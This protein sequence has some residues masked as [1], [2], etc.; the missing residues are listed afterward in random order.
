M[1]GRRTIS[2]LTPCYN[3]EEGIAECHRRIRDLFATSLSGYDY[4]HVFIDN[5]SLDR[6]VEILKAIAATDRRVKIIV[7]SRNFGAARS[8]FHGVLETRGNAVIPVLAD[9]QTP[10]DVIPELIAKWEEGYSIVAAVRTGSDEGWFIGQCRKVFYSVM[11]RFSGIEQIPNFIGFGLYDQSV[12]ALMRE[13]HEPEPYFR[14]M[15]CE[16]G[17]EKAFVPYQQPPRRHGKSSYNFIGL[18]D[19]AVLGLTSYS[20]VPLRIMTIAGVALSALSML[21]AI[22]YLVIKLVRWETFELG[23]APLLIGTFFFA[24]VQLLFVGLIG[25]YVGAIYAQVKRR[26]LVIERERVNFDAP[27]P[28]ANAD[29]A[30]SDVTREPHSAVSP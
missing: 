19:Y 24:S 2:I 15:V 5:C 13:L 30:Y 25:E 4:E 10:P 9:L 18:L 17:F 6:T 20:K 22:S 3:E 23:L 11:T 14:G 26:P 1:M 29:K 16:M 8:S 12:I 28:P 21:V 7:N 27:V